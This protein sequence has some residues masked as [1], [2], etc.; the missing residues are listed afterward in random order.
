MEKTLSSRFS[1]FKTKHLTKE[2]LSICF[3]ILIISNVKAQDLKLA[4]LQ[5]VN[6][7]KSEI[8]DTEGNQ[9]ASF[10]EFGAFVNIP[11]R[12]KNNKS[13]IVN[14]LGYGFVEA[15]RYNSLALSDNDLQKKLQKFYYQFTLMHQFNQKWNVLVNLKPTLA[16]DFEQSLS[17]DDFNFQSAFI[18]TR[19]IND[20]FKLGAGVAN[21]MRLGT[22][23]FTPVV[24][25]YYK[26]NRHQLDALL[27]LNLKYTYAFLHEKKLKLG[28][29][30]GING[31]DFNVAPIQDNEVDKINYSRANLGLLVNYQLTP[32]LRLKANGGI[33]A[34]RI[35]HMEDVHGNE[36]DFDS[37]AAPYF[38]AGIVLV[39]PKR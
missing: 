16:S 12:L 13:V 33:S 4:G 31:A 5:Y 22:L 19:I 6:Y 24:N 37:E 17:S 38:N 39:P 11:L 18:A 7:G 25:F 28:L 21:T 10:Q 2:G 1:M 3:F 36:Y 27:P 30:Y 15:S 34:R 14:G 26:N 29:N 8:K 32:S 20:K 9:E 35:Y 23:R